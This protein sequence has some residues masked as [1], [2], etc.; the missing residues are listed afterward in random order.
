MTKTQSRYIEA[1]RTRLVEDGWKIDPQHLNDT[2][3]D[4][5]AYIPYGTATL[6][7]EPWALKWPPLSDCIT[8]ELNMYISFDQSGESGQALKVKAYALPEY[9]GDINLL[10]SGIETAVSTL[11]KV[12]SLFGRDIGKLK[13]RDD[14]KQQNVAGEPGDGKESADS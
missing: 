6:T 7:L 13:E 12:A 9:R 8:V 3:V 4:W 2:G 5:M 10:L 14:G 1:L 11:R